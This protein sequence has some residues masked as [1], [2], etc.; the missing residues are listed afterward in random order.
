MVFQAKSGVDVEKTSADTQF[1]I[2]TNSKLFSILSDS[3]YTQKI[4]AVIR[5]LCCNAFD[6]HAEARQDRKFQ[7]TLPS[8]FNPEFRVRDFGFGL[9]ED[10]MQMYTTYG[11]STKSGS[12]AYIGA[13]G[14]GAKSPFAYTNTFN[15]TSYNGGAARAYS[16]FVEDGVPRMTKLGE[17]PSDE[18]SGLEVFFPVVL[19]D[20]A[21]FR[22]K[23]IAICALMADKIEF[24]QAGGQWL[25]GFDLEVKKYKWDAA[26]YLGTGY[27]T[28]EIKVD[29][30]YNQDYLFIVQGNVRYEMSTHE[31][32]EML[33]QTLGRE[34]DKIVNRA[35]A[36]FYITGFLRVPNGTF[37]PHPSRE[38][39]TFDEFTK[40]AIKDI[41]SKIYRYHVEDA[42]DRA[43][44]GV[45]SYYDL[46]CRTRNASRLISTNPRIV[47][48][49]N[50][51]QNIH[52]GARVIRNY[53]DWLRFDFSCIQITGGNDKVYRFKNTP[54]LSIYG[55]RIERIY[56]TAKY[57]LSSEYRYRVLGDKIQSGVKNAI[58]LFGDISMVFT[59]DD[60][61]TFVNVQSLP[62][63]I[64]QN[65]INLTASEPRVTREEV[66]FLKVSKYERG[67]S[68]IKF[69]QQA[70]DKIPDMLT[71]FPVYWVGS[72]RRYEFQ[73][74]SAFFN[75]KVQ[76][77][78]DDLSRN[79]FR[80]FFDYAALKN[81][82]AKQGGSL[83]FGVAVL[84]QGHPLRTMLPKLEDSLIDGVRF[85]A[86]D[87]MNKDFYQINTSYGTDVLFN[88]LLTYPELLAR[89]T[90]G[91]GGKRF[92]DFFSGWISAGRPK[93]VHE[94]KQL[95]LPFNLLP[96]KE[97]ELLQKD[98]Y[99]RRNIKDLDI[100]SFYE[101]LGACGFPLLRSFSW[102]GVRDVDA[103]G[104]LMDYVINKAAHLYPGGN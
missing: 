72:N 80:F 49:S 40:A 73:L 100:C 78:K 58:V 34:Y 55:N 103:A 90:T 39:L 92:H 47:Q 29:T 51:S 69:Y 102:S 97:G 12:N 60:K 5:E 91:T 13:F 104:D 36:N 2:A 93:F 3:I 45:K 28:C 35:K 11:E 54:Q 48:F 44:N 82:A 19:K 43:L 74:G 23:S 101:F 25:A 68:G 67:N 41:F 62:K 94:I 84:P 66:S 88:Y 31:I 14:I 75:L 56:Y 24:M 79:Y 63:F 98:Y 57:P 96:V 6:A 89:I 83:Q 52:S 71:E 42:I 4:D 1:K 46:Y 21:E 16:M 70:A 7:V 65:Q 50:A 86:T 9:G 30:D 95:P 76:G 15:V 27:A 20:I 37:V 32:V 59:E 61:A 64:S 38:R 53:A 17:S 85:I 77:D 18:P 81:P 26:D 87:F 8:E 33:K 99:S 22:K 10:D